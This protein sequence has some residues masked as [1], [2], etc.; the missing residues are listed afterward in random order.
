MRQ[1]GHWG[2]ARPLASDDVRRMLKERIE[3]INWKQAAEDA[4]PFIR[5]ARAVVLWRPELFNEAAGRIIWG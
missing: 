2:E 5:D 3:A 1:S 4:L